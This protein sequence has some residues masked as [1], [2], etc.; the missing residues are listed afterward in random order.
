MPSD[1]K[2]YYHCIECGSL[3]DVLRGESQEL[4]CPHCGCPPTGKADALA[5]GGQDG[6]LKPRLGSKLH[7]VNQDTQDIYRATVESMSAPDSAAMS[8]IKRAK[9][10][11]QKGRKWVFVFGAWFVLMSIIVVGI[12]LIDMDDGAGASGNQETEGGN[13]AVEE[14][15]RRAFLRAALP[16]CEQAMSGFLSARTAEGKTQFVHNGIKLSGRITRYYEKNPVY[17]SESSA[18]RIVKG[19]L[20]SM[21][22]HVMVG[23]LCV[24]SRGENWEVVFIKQG[25]EWKI[26]WL[27]MVRYD[28]RRWSTFSVSKDGEEGEFRLYMRVRD[29]NEDIEQ[30]E[31]KLV[32]YKPTIYRAGEFEGESSKPVSVEIDSDLGRQIL[33]MAE[34][35]QVEEGEWLADSYGLSIGRLDPPRYLRAR[36]RMKLHR[37]GEGGKMVR[38]EL[39][40]ILAEHWYGVK[41]IQD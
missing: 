16:Q 7:G 9:R 5:Q 6:R 37:E 20:L 30:K 11:E 15:E 26:D 8:E 22:G 13:L 32:F 10:K 40:D 12:K 36:V 14:T 1:N 31:L 33:R 29:S 34:A 25:D 38:L 23:A 39:L 19:E 35:N 3:F 17:V 2:S 28:D 41:P 21:K 24:N 27:A 4:L 18:F